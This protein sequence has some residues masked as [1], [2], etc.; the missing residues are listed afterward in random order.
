MADDG[1]GGRKNRPYPQHTLEEA[2]PVAQKI[3]DEMGGKPFKR[4]LLADALGIKPS[5]SNFRMLLSSSRQYGLTEG[6]EKASEIT[7][8]KSGEEAVQTTD[9]AKRLAARRAAAMTPEVFAKFFT[10]YADKK[11]PSPEMIGKVLASEY[12][13]PSTHTEECATIIT[14][15][16]R[17]TDLIRD[18]GGSPHVLLDT[19]PVPRTDEEDI[20]H[21]SIV[22]EAEHVEDTE[23]I[24][25]NVVSLGRKDTSTNT[26][27]ADVKRPIFVSHGKKRAPLEKLQK[28]LGSFDIPHKVVVE[29]ANLG[30]PISAKVKETMDQCGSAILIF[31]RDELFY[32]KDGNEIWRPSQNVVHELGAASYAYEDRVVIFKEKGITFPT[33]F[34]NVGYIEFEED[35]IEA[36]TTDLLKELIGFGLVRIT[37]AA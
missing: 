8:T 19:V 1:H 2:L 18:I 20:E 27:S 11:M 21:E 3:H 32:D 5:S 25:D 7:L 35:S 36:K 31:T 14:A 17:F 24:D 28:I 6:T 26:P 37:T 30:R 16:G 4:L 22:D 9:S 10:D 29:E 12:G 13:V 15:N 33:N 23:D 34:Q